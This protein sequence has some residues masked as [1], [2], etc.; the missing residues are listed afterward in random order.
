MYYIFFSGAHSIPQQSSFYSAR[1]TSSFHFSFSLCFYPQR[2]F[3]PSVIRLFL[4][5]NTAYPLLSLLA[6]NSKLSSILFCSVE[7]SRKRKFITSAV[8]LLASQEHR[9]LSLPLFSHAAV[10]SLSLFCLLF[11][12]R[13]LIPA[14]VPVPRRSNTA[15]SC[16]LFRPLLSPSPAAE[17][18]HSRGP[19]LS[20]QTPPIRHCAYFSANRNLAPSVTRLT[21]RGDTGSSVILSAALEY[22]Q[23]ASVSGR[24]LFV[25]S[26]RA[27][28]I[29]FF[30]P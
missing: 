7:S 14:T 9:F 18:S 10:T 16:A 2:K 24:V 20:P 25:C 26:L 12:F 27:F 4:Q 11:C 22:K 5:R 19:F 3:T 1:A 21:T 17:A 6:C 30:I 28:G 23:L 15:L 13:Q 8:H 29:V